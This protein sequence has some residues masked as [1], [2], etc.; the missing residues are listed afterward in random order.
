MGSAFRAHKLHFADDGKPRG[1]RPAQRGRQTSMLYFPDS[2]SVAAVCFRA[3]H[4]AF[5]FGYEAVAE[6]PKAENA[7]S[8]TYSAGRTADRRS[9]V[10]H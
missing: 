4:A 8:L 10:T 9:F 6:S 3:H 5:R 2:A 7:Q 1:G